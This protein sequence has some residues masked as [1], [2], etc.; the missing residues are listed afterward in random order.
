VTLVK[1]CGLRTLS[2]A[3]T[4]L[5]AGA[6][7]LGFNFW[8]PGKRYIAPVEAA[9]IIDTLKSRSTKWSAVGVFADPTLEEVEAATHVCHLDYVQLSGNEPAN[10]VA[11]MPRPT[12]KAIHV[13]GGHEAAAVETVTTNALGAHLYLLDTHADGMPGGTGV[14]FDWNALKAV[15][16]RCFVA[17]G[18]RPDNVAS[19]LAALSPLG[20]DVASGVEFSPTPTPTQTQT[21]TQTPTLTTGGKDPALVRA[22]LEAVRSYDDS[23]A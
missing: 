6:D 8:M 23:H 9:R 12:I 16:P 11:A 21:Q 7:L 17:G 13:R 3:R 5:D 10:M 14:T 18:L 4:A 2:D 15:G 22:F 20:V 19:A 1:V